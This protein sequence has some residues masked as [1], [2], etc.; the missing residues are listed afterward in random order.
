ML[1][2][3]AAPMLP[4]TSAWISS[5]S[6]PPGDTRL[7]GLATAATIS[8]DIAENASPN[9]TP[10]MALD[11]KISHS[12]GVPAKAS[13]WPGALARHPSAW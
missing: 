11:K 1:A 12:L 7:P 5:C 4:P 9:P 3:T 2:M 8:A 10:M 13:P 6:M